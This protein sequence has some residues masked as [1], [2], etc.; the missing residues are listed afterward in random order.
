MWGWR[1]L[2]RWD[3]FVTFRQEKKEV[4]RR[5]F[6]YLSAIDMLF[7]PE[8]DLVEISV[9][10]LNAT[11][12]RPHQVFHLEPKFPVL[13]R[14]EL[15]V[16]FVPGLFDVFVFWRRSA[17]GLTDWGVYGDSQEISKWSYRRLDVLT[18]KDGLLAIVEEFLDGCDAS[19][20]RTVKNLRER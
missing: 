14:Q 3:Q 8:V 18:A 4:K 15:E 13:R 9:F 6:K 16:L 17:H 20:S 12:E 5:Q 1:S 2:S 7:E 19:V 11:L 10:D